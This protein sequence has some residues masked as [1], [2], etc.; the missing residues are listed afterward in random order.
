M[1]AY[2]VYRRRDAENLMLGLDQ[3]RERGVTPR[4]QDYYRYIDREIDESKVGDD[5]EQ[6]VERV[7]YELSSTGWKITVG[8]VVELDDKYWFI[9]NIGVKELSEFGKEG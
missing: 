6:I 3:L 8:D 4:M 2:K 7:Y 5:P 9:D 1:K